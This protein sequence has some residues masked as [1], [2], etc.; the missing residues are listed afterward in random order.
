[1][2]RD[3]R[4][5]AAAARGPAYLNSDGN[6][7]GFLEAEGSHSLEHFIND[8]ARDI[9]DPETQLSVWKRAHARAIRPCETR[10]QGKGPQ[11]RRLADWRARFGIRLHAVPAAPRRAVVEHRVRRRGLERHL[12]LDLRRLLF[13]HAFP[14]HRLRVRA[15][16]RRN[17]W[18]SGDSAGRRRHLPFRYANLADTVRTYDESCSS[19]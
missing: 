5:R 15:D 19:W 11:P 18:N 10:R 3:A 14:R 17:R 4:D 1:V 12:P 13:L 16:A 7:R 6:G 9:I 2:G 8:V